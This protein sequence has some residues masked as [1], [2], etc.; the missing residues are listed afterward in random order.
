MAINHEQLIQAL[1]LPDFDPIPV[2]LPMVPSKRALAPPPADH[3]L[4]AVLALFY[5]AGER[6][7]V[8]LLKRPMTMRNH[9]GQIAFP[10]GR[11]DEGE[12]F[13][14]TAI[15]ETVEEIGITADQYT[16]VGRIDPLY[17]PPSR[18]YVHC[19]VGWLPTRPT[20]IPNPAEVE[21]IIEVPYTHFLD[22]ANR[23]ASEQDFGFGPINIP[24]FAFE[25][26]EIWG[27]TSVLL[28]EL[29]H[30]IHVV[31]QQTAE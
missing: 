14:Q 12:T 28:N 20:Y 7:N 29:A 17:I 15:R 2:R 16:I 22:P 10:G 8:V 4:G 24:Y 11:Q 13:E 6:L 26:H 31:A 21:T 30:R 3:R 19:F 18:F 5:P 27:A 23:G 1:N 9:P 25:A